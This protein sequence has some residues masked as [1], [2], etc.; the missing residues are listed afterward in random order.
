MTNSA[1]ESYLTAEILTAPPQKLHLLLIEGAIRFAEKS[2]QHR[3]AGEREAACET[4]ILAQ[5]IVAQILAG[6][7]R[8]AAPALVGKIASIY[9]FVHRSLVEAGIAPDETKLDGALRALEAERTTWRQLCGKLA[10][11][12]A[13]SGDARPRAHI[14]PAEQ[15]SGGLSL[16]A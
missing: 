8:D 7:N 13:E 9:L 4:L 10:G 12:P 2:R 16:D 3:R 5:E 11:S 14:P 1:R 6:L 15:Y